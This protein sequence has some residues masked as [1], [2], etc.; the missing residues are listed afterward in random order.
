[1]E[2]LVPRCLMVELDQDVACF[3]VAALH[4][5]EQ[6]NDQINLFNP[7][8]KTVDFLEQQPPLTV[9]DRQNRYEARLPTSQ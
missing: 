6:F 4:N 9:V 5:S 8:R 2:D 1:M 3:W 7:T